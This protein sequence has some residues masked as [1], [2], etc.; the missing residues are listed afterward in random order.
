MKRYY[1]TA[2]AVFFT[3]G[4]S[5]SEVL[6]P[7][8]EKVDIYTNTSF[9]TETV[10]VE[11]GR[12]NILVVIPSFAPV[13]QI[14][15]SSKAGLC[16]VFSI[17][18]TNLNRKAVQSIERQI[19]EYKN[20]LKVVDKTIFLIEKNSVNL[21]EKE[22]KRFKGLYKKE[23]DEKAYI[24]RAIEN[25]KKKLEEEKSK[26]FL[27]VNLRCEGDDNLV[28]VFPANISSYQY[29]TVKGFT[30][31][32][33]ISIDSYLD[34]KNEG[35]D[36][37]NVDLVFHSFF[38]TSLIEPP[39]FESPIYP[40]KKSLRLMENKPVRKYIETQTKAY[41]LVKNI[42]IPSKTQETVLISKNIYNANFDIFI[43]GYA[44]VTPFLRAEFKPDKTFFPSS[45]KY[46]IDGVFVGTG[47]LRP[48]K[49]N[50]K[51]NLFFGEDLF[52]DVVK[53]NVEDFWE[54][55]FFG[56]KVH[57]VKWF[58]SLK[59]RHKKAV[60][61]TLVDKI[62]VSHSENIKVEPFSTF[63]WEKI[64]KNGKVIWIFSLKPGEKKEFFFGYKEE[65]KK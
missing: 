65:I 32:G 22:I 44:T 15:V 27:S 8:P 58:Y 37:K 1:L 46:Y 53:N 43:D 45:A 36:L 10:P 26:K 38:K 52:V 13:N 35:R 2:L 39:S 28:F 7:V 6:E 61:I 12:K 42:D 25:L 20:R 14:N 23:L 9:I 54:K 64:E 18:E 34:I 11:K 19:E 29:Y 5:S 49:A 4:V 16:S 17:E 3:A 57:T 48:L 24:L 55:N 31:E 60:R 56:K 21:S 30:E 59:N 63:K 33:K 41:F 62:P 50:E 51:N 40:V 47:R